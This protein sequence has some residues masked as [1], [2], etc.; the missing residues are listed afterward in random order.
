[1]AEGI[2]F[3]KT[4]LFSVFFVITVL[5]VIPNPIPNLIYFALAFISVISE[6]AVEELSAINTMKS[7]FLPIALIAL[8]QAGGN[9]TN[10]EL[11]IPVNYCP[12]W[13]DIR[14][15][16]VANNFI[17]EKYQASTSISFLEISIFQQIFKKIH[18]QLMF[19]NL[20]FHSIF[21]IFHQGF[22]YEHAKQDVTQP[23]SPICGCPAIDWRFLS[24]EASETEEGLD[25]LDVG[26]LRCPKIEG[27]D[28]KDYFSNM[29]IELFD[30]FPGYFIESWYR[31]F[32]HFSS[33][34]ESGL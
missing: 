16:Y 26:L 18:R 5:L 32:V 25:V 15:E 31:N 12:H 14:S 21:S 30:E 13:F 19:A 24:E 22:W 2:L 4:S 6:R 11:P 29:T 20:Q 27:I 34:T 33:L 10:P 23:R 9:D 28:G 7:I 3:Y 8:V 1:M 17:N